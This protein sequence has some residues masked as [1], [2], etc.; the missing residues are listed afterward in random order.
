MRSGWHIVIRG[1][2][3]KPCGGGGSGGLDIVGKIRG[4]VRRLRGI[5]GH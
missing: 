5:T 4:D 2:V 3:R 1:R